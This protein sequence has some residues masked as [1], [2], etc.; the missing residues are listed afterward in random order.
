MTPIRISIKTSLR[1]FVINFKVYL[2]LNHL[3]NT[4]PCNSPGGCGPHC[5]SNNCN[6]NS[7]MPTVTSAVVHSAVALISIPV[8]L[9]HLSLHC[10]DD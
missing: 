4:N 10:G 1:L 5:H 7:I 6:N 9:A 2:T 8:T 3:C